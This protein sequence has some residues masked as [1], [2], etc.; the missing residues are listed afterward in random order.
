MQLSNALKVALASSSEVEL[1]RLVRH[2]RKG[3]TVALRIVRKGKKREMTME[4]DFSV[5]YLRRLLAL[6]DAIRAA[7]REND[8]ITIKVGRLYSVILLS[9][10]S[11]K[12]R[13]MVPRYWIEHST[14]TI[15]GSKSPLAPNRKH[16]F[17]TLSNVSLWNWSGFYAEPINPETAGVEAVSAYGQYK[18]WQ[19][20]APAAT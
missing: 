13:Q 11:G 7:G 2:K 15:F 18:H 20:I 10:G 6:V 17:G 4:Q 19:P 3:T 12:Q 14:E 1:R 8:P 5:D 16:Y 9:M